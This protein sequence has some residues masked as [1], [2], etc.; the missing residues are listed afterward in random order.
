ME[1]EKLKQKI[2]D[3]AIRG[4][5]VPQDP[6]D[7]PA[8]VLIERIR[9]EKEKLIK[10]GKI[11]RDKN[12]SYIYLGSDNCYYENIGNSNTKLSIPTIPSNWV[13]VRLSTISNKI[14]YGLGYPS[15]KEGNNKYLRITDIQNNKVDWNSVP[16]I[17]IKDDERQYLLE[18]NDI[19][20]ARTGATVGKS[21]LVT[22]PPKNATFASYLIRVE[23]T[24]KN[25]AKYIN[26]F[27]QSKQYWNQIIDKSVGS[28]QPNC[29]GTKLSSLLIPIPPIKELGKIVDKLDDMLPKINNIMTEKENLNTI[30]E[31]TK[32]R[33]LDFYFGDDSC[34]K[35]YYKFSDLFLFQNGYAFS[36]LDYSADGIKII[37]ISD[38]IDNKINTLYCKKVNNMYIDEKFIVKKGDLLIAM[39]GATTGKMGVFEENEL[40]YLNQRVGNIK[41]KDESIILPKY[42]NYLFM[43]KR[44]EILK[45]AYG[46]AQPN[47]S[48]NTIL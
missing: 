5:L 11:K 17:N 13:W 25:I 15:K 46:G 45:L 44:N 34:Y 47:I 21:Y 2:L 28:G 29:N 7:E 30:I 39:S 20:F 22:N 8:S 33:I 43:H 31:K 16:F 23:L 36:S 26:Y 35:S 4:K 12:E 32:V 14:Q 40:C 1:I 6:D 18:N 27:F 48:S 3:L 10:E 42:R 41:I 9:E 24:N 19:V 37:R 38:L